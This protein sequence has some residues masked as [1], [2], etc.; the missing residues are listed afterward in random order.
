MKLQEF[1][2]SLIKTAA[3]GK[4]MMNILIGMSPSGKN[5]LDALLALYDSY[6]EDI[7]ANLKAFA[8]TFAHLF[9]KYEMKETH[10]PYYNKFSPIWGPSELA[11]IKKKYKDLLKDDAKQ[12]FKNSLEFSK[13]LGSR[14]F[15]NSAKEAFD[16]IENHKDVLKS[17]IAKSPSKF[18][19]NLGKQNCWENLIQSDYDRFRALCIDIKIDHIAVLKQEHS[20]SFYGFK[21]LISKTEDINLEKIFKETNEYPNFFEGSGFFN[22]KSKRNHVTSRQTNIFEAILS[23]LSQNKHNSFYY[24]FTTYPDEI[25]NCMQDYL[26]DKN[27]TVDIFNHK[28]W[29]NVLDS[30]LE[31]SKNHYN[32]EAFQEHEMKVISASIKNNFKII[33][34]IILEKGL[35]QKEESKPRK[36]KI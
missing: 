16:F 13:A 17:V 6:P 11:T 33:N 29:D 5:V 19:E 35:S 3:E 14:S 9:T 23:L 25:K 28:H 10:L 34:A 27:Q 1:S 12:S 22:P 4:S 20:I 36:M 2:A 8:P 24:L 32:R 26:H 21:Y 15:R 30:M 31:S 7:K 18:I